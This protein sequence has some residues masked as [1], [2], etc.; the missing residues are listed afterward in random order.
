MRM[1]NAEIQGLPND[2]LLEV[3][4]RDFDDSN[5]LLPSSS[6]QNEQVEGDYDED[7]INYMN[8]SPVSEREQ[9]SEES[10]DDDVSLANCLERGQQAKSPLREKE[11]LNA[12]C[13]CLE[14]KTLLWDLLQDGNVVRKSSSFSFIT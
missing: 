9:E 11:E 8:V 10:E 14:G 5:D 1:G 13:L 7:E 3:S 12:E 6:F 2:N 4:P